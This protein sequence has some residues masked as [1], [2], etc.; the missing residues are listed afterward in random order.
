MDDRFELETQIVY[1]KLEQMTDE[2]LCE[3]V[4]SGYREAEDILAARYARTVRS[5]ARPYFLAGGDSEDLIQEGM[6]G[7][8]SAI[9]EYDGE[10]AGFSTFLSICVKRRIY[11][12]IRNAQG[13]KNDILNM[14]MSFEQL[15]KDHEDVS[16]H[17]HTDRMSDPESFVIDREEAMLLSQAIDRLL[18]AFERTVLML[19]LR[20]FSYSEM[21]LHLNCP[22]K[23]IDN[24]V[25]RIRR[26]LAHLI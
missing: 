16:G 23:S 25:Q 3:L 22:A 15:S 9:R 6:L 24:A 26:K 5:L 19:Y 20:G 12:A 4:R 10:K 21:S 8:V 1:E 11:T 14:A 18:S 17:L 2:A 13:K 7:L